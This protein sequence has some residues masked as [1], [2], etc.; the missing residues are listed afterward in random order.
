MIF[1]TKLKENENE[2]KPDETRQS[3]ERAPE[4]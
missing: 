2:T 1:E 3:I 4:L